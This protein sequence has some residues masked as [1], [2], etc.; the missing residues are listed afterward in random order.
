MKPPEKPAAS[1]IF[2][3]GPLR[4]FLTS[5]GLWVENVHVATAGAAVVFRV[6]VELAMALGREQTDAL[7]PV[8]LHQEVI[9]ELWI[10]PSQLGIC[11]L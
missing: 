8:A 1:D 6:D 7:R 9:L 11:S 4:P 3:L 10:G 5:P 2:R